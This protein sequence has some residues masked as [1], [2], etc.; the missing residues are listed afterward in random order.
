M[1]LKKHW[2]TLFAAL[3]TMAVVGVSATSCGANT[4]STISSPALINKV[5]VAAQKGEITATAPVVTESQFQD[6]NEKNLLNHISIQGVNESEK[7][8]LNVIDFQ[9]EVQDTSISFALRSDRS[10]SGNITVFW[11]IGNPNENIPEN[12]IKIQFA[13]NSRYPGSNRGVYGVGDTIRMV[14]KSNL[15]AGATNINYE[16]AAYYPDQKRPGAFVPQV[17]Q[18]KNPSPKLSYVVD[19]KTVSCPFYIAARVYFTYNGQDSYLTL[20]TNDWLKVITRDTND[21][22]LVYF[23]IE[24]S[25]FDAIKKGILEDV[26]S[27][28]GPDQP[29]SPELG[30]LTLLDGSPKMLDFS[31]T[32]GIVHMKIETRFTASKDPINTYRIGINTFDFDLRLSEKYL[33]QYDITQIKEKAVSVDRTF[34]TLDANNREVLLEA[35]TDH[36]TPFDAYVTFRTYAEEGSK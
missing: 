10:V 19:K 29:G 12:Q 34:S 16:W 23:N 32:N 7:N 1:K 27:A 18:E 31:F 4:V 33:W 15:P 30:K 9:S 6:I 28:Y 13:G 8:K 25:A 36:I 24:T 5:N 11:T 22:V 3:G 21:G 14:A 17:I 26:K 20:P 2:W 35:A